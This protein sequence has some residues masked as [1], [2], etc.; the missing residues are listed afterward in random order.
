MDDRVRILICHTDGAVHEL[1]LFDGPPEYDDTLNYR[2]SQHKFG[3]GTAHFGS[4]FTVSK[5]DW[6]KKTYRDAILDEIAKHTRPGE[7]AGMG[8]TFYDVKNNFMQDALV[9]WKKHNRTL[10]CGDYMTDKMR[11]YPDT[12]ADRK[13]LGLSVKERPNT[14]LCQFCPVNS[15]VMGKK[16]KETYG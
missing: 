6:E 8:Q 7:G 4:M 14:F 5:A 3:D 1:P 10:D 16:N 13:E 9:C 2:T 15:V 11:L 12:K